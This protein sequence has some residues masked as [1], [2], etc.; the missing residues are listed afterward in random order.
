[1]QIRM[2]PHICV[3]L[4]GKGMESAG[5]L[6][7][8]LTRS[9]SHWKQGRRRAEVT[10]DTRGPCR[11]QCRPDERPGAYRSARLPVGLLPFLV[12]GVAGR[13]LAAGAGGW[14]GQLGKE[15]LEDPQVHQQP[16]L[17]ERALVRQSQP[18]VRRGEKLETSGGRFSWTPRGI[19][20]QDIYY[21]SNISCADVCVQK[22]K[23]PK[24]Y[25][26][27]PSSLA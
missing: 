18:L 13:I 25:T 10:A 4:Q 3:W 14:D 20:D 12:V 6:W 22:Q 11:T 5:R 8:R 9:L 7:E 1:M 16:I 23:I 26:R 21:I 15:G 17:G 2:C 19:S 24:R 27:Q